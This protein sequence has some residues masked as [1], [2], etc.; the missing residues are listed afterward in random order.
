M[1]D[2]FDVLFI[3]SF[4]RLE[5]LRACFNVFLDALFEIEDQQIR[6]TDGIFESVLLVG[7]KEILNV[8]KLVCLFEF[9]KTFDHL[10]DDLVFT[11]GEDFGLHVSTR[12]IFVILLECL[13]LLFVFMIELVEDLVC[14]CLVD[15]LKLFEELHL[16][17]GLE[18]FDNLFELLDTQILDDIVEVA[19]RQ[20]ECDITK[21]RFRDLFDRF[22]EL[23]IAKTTKEFRDLTCM[24][25]ALIMRI[26]VFVKFVKAHKIFLSGV[27]K[28]NFEWNYSLRA[29][30]LCHFGVTERFF[31]R[32]AGY[33]MRHIYFLGVFNALQRG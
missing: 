9:R 29:R 5:V 15:I 27:R 17:I 23:V 3:V 13:D 19:I 11:C 22:I 31:V 26:D 4:D 10:F 1:H 21:D 14:Y 25:F 28:L 18:L 24:H 12:F 33:F 32:I 20:D 8:F 16:V 2:I 6:Q 30:H 7:D